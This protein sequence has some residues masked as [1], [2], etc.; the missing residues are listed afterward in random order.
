MMMIDDEEEEEEDEDE[1]EDEDGDG[2]GDG[3]G[4]DGDDGDDDDG[5]GGDGGGDGDS[6]DGD[7]DDDASVDVVHVYLMLLLT[8]SVHSSIRPD[9]Q[10]CIR[11]FGGPEAPPVSTNQ[12]AAAQKKPRLRGSA[13][14]QKMA[15]ADVP[16]ATTA[17]TQF[18]CQRENWGLRQL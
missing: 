15:S 4:D 5:G 11:S 18:L 13:V 1:D 2:D 17:S 10:T 6:D 8:P 16:K 14:R 9:I 7:D 3:D 12:Q